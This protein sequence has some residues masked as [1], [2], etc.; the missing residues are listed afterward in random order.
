MPLPKT[1]DVGKIYSFLKK[2][3]KSMPRKQKIAIAL[4]QARRYSKGD[5][6]KAFKEKLA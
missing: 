5:V 6:Q 3:S 2:E 1:S 4:N